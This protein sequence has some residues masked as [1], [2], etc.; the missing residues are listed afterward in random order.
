[1]RGETGSGAV[2]AGLLTCVVACSIDNSEWMRN[3]DYAPGRMTVQL[4]AANVLTMAKLES[5]AENSVALMTYAGRRFAS[6]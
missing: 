5:H 2:L 6:Y 4:D 3:G 1:M